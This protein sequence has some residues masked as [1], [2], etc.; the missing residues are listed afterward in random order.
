MNRRGPRLAG[1]SDAEILR[2]AIGES[3]HYSSPEPPVSPS[4]EPLP[5]TLGPR[6]RAERR[7]EAARARR[8]GR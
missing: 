8:R 4:I 7:A 3:I 6:N 2:V 5:P 1:L